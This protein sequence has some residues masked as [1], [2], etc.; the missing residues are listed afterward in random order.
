V[1]QPRNSKL[2]ILELVLK[3][4]TGKSVSVAFFAGVATA[5]AAG[6]NSK[7]ADTQLVL[8][9]QDRIGERKY[10]LTLKTQ[11]WKF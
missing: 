7:S 3:D 11:N 8:W 10:G 2:T 4:H 5:I 1:L 6:R 9:L